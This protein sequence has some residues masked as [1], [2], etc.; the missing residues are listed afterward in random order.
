MVVNRDVR[1][2]KITSKGIKVKE[3]RFSG[4][5]FTRAQIEKIVKD[6]SEALYEEG[7]NGGI[8]VSMFYP[9][10]NNWKSSFDGFVEVG[11]MPYLFSYGEYDGNQLEDPAYYPKFTIFIRKLPERAGGCNGVNNDCLYI[12]L[13]KVLGDKIPWKWQGALK[14]QLKLFMNE[15]ISID[16][17]PKVQEKLKNYQ[18]V[19]TGDHEFIGPEKK[20]KI[21]LKLIDGHY[22][23]DYSENFKIR[24]INR[25][26]KPFL[27]FKPIED[28]MYEVFDGRSVKKLP[29]DEINQMK[30]DF[31]NCKYTLV[32]TEEDPKEKYTELRNASLALK[33]ATNNRINLFK[34]GSYATTAEELFRSM[35]YQYQPPNSEQNEAEWIKKASMGA[36]IFNEPYTGPCWKYDVVSHYPSILADSHTMFPI[37]T[38]AFHLKTNAQIQENKFF[39]YGIYR[40]I[41]HPHE[42]DKM[43]KIFRFNRFNYYTHFDLNRAMKDGFKLE[44]I[45]DGFVNCMIYDRKSLENGSK[46]FKPFVDYLFDLKQKKIPGAKDLLNSFTGKIFQKDDL[47][48]EFNYGINEGLKM[49][50]EKEL[51]TIVKTGDD[52][53]Y[54]YFEKPNQQFRSPYARCYPFLL[55]K[56]RQKITN[57]MKPHMEHVVRCHT[58]SMFLKKECNVKTGNNLGDLKY[59]GYCPKAIVKNNKIPTGEFTM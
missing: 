10:Y 39:S 11:Y 2:L 20:E 58:D 26:G 18:L 19:V 22:S 51:S 12:C 54:I 25:K 30:K 55:A 43:N 52:S 38:P 36:V 8:M 50:G 28:D 46:L 34:T 17:L 29:R 32:Y 24:R 56:G 47:P 53:Y 45:E 6:Y 3:I 40:A 7:F 57:I 23:Q 41:V 33:K 59:E 42:V 4:K 44:L 9:D 15:K 27:T 13:E 48:L 21:R 35:S 5:N 37:N 49:W 31:L 14:R 1:E 16:D